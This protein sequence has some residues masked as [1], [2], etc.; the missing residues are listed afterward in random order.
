MAKIRTGSIGIER[1]NL[2]RVREIAARAGMTIGRGKQPSM[3]STDQLLDAIAT[4]DEEHVGR[5]LAL[6]ESAQTVGVPTSES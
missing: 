1:D 6:L 3:G 5:L 2:L 4:L